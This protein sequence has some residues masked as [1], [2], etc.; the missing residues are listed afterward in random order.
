MQMSFALWMALARTA[1]VDNALD[2]EAQAWLGGIDPQA[3]DAPT[4]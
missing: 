1:P 4:P 3:D 2:H